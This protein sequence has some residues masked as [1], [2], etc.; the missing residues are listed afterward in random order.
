MERNSLKGFTLIELLTVVGVMA[1]LSLV[2]ITIYR[3]AA[4]KNRDDIRKNDLSSLA[5]VLAV[6]LELSYSKDSRYIINSD[7][8]DITACPTSTDATSPLYDQLLP[9]FPSGAV[10]K[11]PKSGELYCYISLNNGQAYRLFAK[12]ERCN[13]SDA[14]TICGQTWS[15]SVYSAD[16]TL[17]P[18]PP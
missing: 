13:S 2:G 15:Y 5:V 9:L 3:E 14:N 11:D 17:S 18:A 7:G 8:E 12:L 10:P 6:V 4:S 1:V 16:L